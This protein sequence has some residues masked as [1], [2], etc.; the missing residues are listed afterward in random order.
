M[1][2]YGVAGGSAAIT[3]AQ[4]QQQEKLQVGYTQQITSKVAT[5]LHLQSFGALQKTT[6]GEDG[7]VEKQGVTVVLREH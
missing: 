5:G 6:P 2:F 4:S 1:S 3:L 7:V